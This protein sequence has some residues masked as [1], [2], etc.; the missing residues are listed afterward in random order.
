MFQE[1]DAES[2]PKGVAPAVDTH[3][4]IKQSCAEGKTSTFHGEC[5]CSIRCSISRAD[6][7]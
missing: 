4:D 3:S 5:M 7:R 6:E 2:G 1:I